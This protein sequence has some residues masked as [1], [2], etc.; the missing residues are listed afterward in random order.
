VAELLR[1]ISPVHLH[2]KLIRN[3]RKHKLYFYFTVT[4]YVSGLVKKNNTSM[5]IFRTPTFAAG[6]II[7]NIDYD[8]LRTYLVL[9]QYK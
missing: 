2:N 4:H 9:M 3:I 7:F 6:D 1:T 5:E 8:D